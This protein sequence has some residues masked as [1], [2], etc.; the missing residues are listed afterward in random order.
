MFGCNLPNDLGADLFVRPVMY[1]R[2]QMCDCPQM[3]LRPA[4]RLCERP[5]FFVV[6]Q[7]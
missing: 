5:V 2:L 1:I 4:F 3:F 6:S 7:R